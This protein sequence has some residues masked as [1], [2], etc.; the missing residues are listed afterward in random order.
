M[1]ANLPKLGSSLPVPCVQEI[2]K[3]PLTTIPPGYVR[4][5]QENPFISYNNSVP[6]VPVVDM[7]RLL[8]ADCLDSELQ[9]LHR[10]CKEWG[11]FQVCL[12]KQ[13]LFKRISYLYW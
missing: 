10:A 11:F 5:D 6:Q 13:V 9:K 3:K 8:S 4:S 1:A 2:A 7:Q 12:R